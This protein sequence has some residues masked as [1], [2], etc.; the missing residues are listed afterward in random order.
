MESP[1]SFETRGGVGKS[2]PDSNICTLTKNAP[3]Y[4]YVYIF[5]SG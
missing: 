3:Y 5:I 4:V 1:I 2:N